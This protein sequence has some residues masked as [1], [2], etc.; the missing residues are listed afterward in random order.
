MNA[1]DIRTQ[2]QKTSGILAGFFHCLAALE[3]I[4]FYKHFDAVLGNDVAHLFQFQ[5]AGKGFGYGE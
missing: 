4:E 5:A 3:A 1:I 2:A